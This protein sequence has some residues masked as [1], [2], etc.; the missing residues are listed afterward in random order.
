MPA[1]T[2]VAGSEESPPLVDTQ[3][4]MTK[5]GVGEN[6]AIDAESQNA[7]WDA[8]CVDVILSQLCP[9]GYAGQREKDAHSSDGECEMSDAG[10]GTGGG[11]TI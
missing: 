6:S 8:G 1:A 9:K 4:P 5:A 3:H 11:L 2:T 7:E 10:I